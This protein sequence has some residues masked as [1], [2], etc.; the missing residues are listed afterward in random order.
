METTESHSS[1]YAAI[2]LQN[3]PNF[4]LAAENPGIAEEKIF[5]ETI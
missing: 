3:K 5:V 4:E 1:C 2:S